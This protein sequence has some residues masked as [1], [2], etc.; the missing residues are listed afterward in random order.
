[1]ILPI[2]R[3]D[4]IRLNL[5]H[6]FTNKPCKNGH[7]AKR[8]TNCGVCEV[9]LK[10]SQDSKEYYSNNADKFYLYSKKYKEKNKEKIKEYQHKYKKEN[11]EK[12][13]SLEVKRSCSKINRTPSWLNKNDFIEIER[14]YK[15]ARVKSKINKKQYHVDHIIP[16]NGKTVSGLHVP[17]NLQVI[18]ASQN[19]IKSNTYI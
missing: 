12:L 15:E 6:Y 1:M 3:K 11:R 19:L 18:L 8:Y 17:S 13:N 16:L 5:T 4:A 10:N 9:C 14:I 7:V 2:S